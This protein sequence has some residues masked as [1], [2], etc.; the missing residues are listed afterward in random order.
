MKK[1]TTLMVRKFLFSFCFFVRI[2]G[3]E[4]ICKYGKGG[5]EGAVGVGGGGG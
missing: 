1:V 4:R 3:E 2:R 5:G